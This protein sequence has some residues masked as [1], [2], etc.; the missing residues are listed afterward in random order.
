M[1]HVFTETGIHKL[2]KAVRAVLLKP[3]TT[4]NEMY[5][6]KKF[7]FT[8]SRMNKKYYIVLKRKKTR[9]RQ[10]KKERKGVRWRRKEG[11]VGE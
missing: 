7:C 10:Q 1:I 6:K 11:R 8:F 5:I 2:G 4:S 9:E 3:L